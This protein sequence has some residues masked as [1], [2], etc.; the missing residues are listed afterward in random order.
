MNL[1]K[2]LIILLVC[3]IATN[4]YAQ[5]QQ[6]KKANSFYKL[7]KYG[8]A[9]DLYE[10]ALQI[11]DNLSASTKLAY[12]YRMTNQTIKAEEWYNKVVANQKAKPITYY[13]YAESLMSNGKYDLAKNWFLK[14]NEK[15]PDDKNAVRMAYA[16]DKIKTLEP[17]FKNVEIQEFEHNSDVDDSAPIYFNDGIVFTSDRPTGLNPLKKKSGWTGR[18]FQ[19]VYFSASEGNGTFKKPT[20]Y[21]K[22]INDLNKHS[23]PVSFSK[24][25]KIVIFTRTSQIASKKNAYNIQLYSA[26]AEDGKKWKN[27]QLL[28]FCNN[29]YNYM[30]PAISPD[31]SKLFFVSDKSGGLGGT[32]I[33]L[34]KR[35]GDK[36]ER[37]QNLGPII[38]TAANEAFP[39]YHESEKLFFCSKGHLSFGGFDILFSNLKENGSWQKPVNVGSPI[40]TSYDDISLY[41]DDSMES[42]MFAS[43]RNGGDDDIY[44]FHIMEGINAELESLDFEGLV[45]EPTRTEESVEEELNL[46]PKPNE[47]VVEEV[48]SVTPP[49]VE[50]T[51]E[52][53]P[54][55]NMEGTIRENEVLEVVREKPSTDLLTPTGTIDNKVQEEELLTETPAIETPSSIQPEA[56]KENVEEEEIV[57][58]ENTVQTIPNDEAIPDRK[59]EILDVPPMETAKEEVVLITT[60]I[61]EPVVEKPSKPIR[62]IPQPAKAVE[63][64]KE[65]KKA[66]KS[67]P[68][69]L[70]IPSKKKKKIIEPKEEYVL[71][72]T[73][74]I[75]KE[76]QATD[77][78]L[79]ETPRETSTAQ[80]NNNTLEEKIVEAATSKEEE[81]ELL[82]ESATILDR[83]PVA[84]ETKKPV[85]LGSEASMMSDRPEALPKLAE[86]LQTNQPV[87]SQGFVVSELDYPRGSYLLSPQ[88]TRSLAMVVDLMNRFPEIK[89]EIGSHTSALGD[90]VEN[91][92]LSRK[93]AMS[94]M[95]FLVYKGIANDRITAKGY[96]ETQLINTCA[97]GVDCARVAHEEN[98]RIEVKLV[99]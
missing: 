94:I 23:G 53:R 45:D 83:E 38:N 7:N 35:K 46:S 25:G 67:K 70:I 13:Y 1:F 80:P 84:S 50:K 8:D 98:D 26:E 63:V 54:I 62:N 5:K 28:S 88:G 17:Y 30:H 95:A 74:V 24:D 89:V 75:K 15:E 4:S 32:D 31:G 58:V 78:M 14:Y 72:E 92:N 43:S 2:T 9:I 51:V 19:K 49:V 16:C 99:E 27:V 40:N 77:L 55:K 57:H 21:S 41:L 69:N 59:F 79:K 73:P 18:D 87:P 48:V 71:E 90:D 11:K 68:L 81:M 42:G 12:C 93:R 33:Y 34:S 39:F 65:E 86:L 91:H 3:F 44:I 6:I 85:L 60:S 47:P 29:S 97:N 52:E 56:I 64:K 96:G 20:D 66:K 76:E 37:P 10:E 22:K 61:E 36:W 82:S